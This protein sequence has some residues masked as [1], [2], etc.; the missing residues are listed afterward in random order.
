MQLTLKTRRPLSP[1]SSREQNSP[2]LGSSFQWSGKFISRDAC[3][4]NAMTLPS[5][6]IA[7]LALIFTIAS[8]WWLQARKGRLKLYPVTT[9]SGAARNDKF[10]LRIPIFLYNTG[11]VPRV[12]TGLRLRWHDDQTQVLEC[13]SFRRTIEATA[14]DVEDYAHPFVVP[15]RDVV[16]KYAHFFAEGFIRHL[17]NRPSVFILEVMVDQKSSWKGVGKILLHTE[18]MNTASYVS[19]TNNSGMWP[20]GNESEGQQ[21]REK[22]AKLRD[23]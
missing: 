14:N 16:T 22:L 1:D 5:V 21:H 18:I 12:I 8:F 9:F 20:D 13:H 4:V 17:S 11:A 7:S 6:I 3:S 23:N 19:Y 2:A 10:A 15:A